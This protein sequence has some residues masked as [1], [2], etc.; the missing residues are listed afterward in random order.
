MDIVAVDRMGRPCGV[1]N[2][3]TAHQLPGTPH[4]AFSVVVAG[5]DGSVLLQRRSAEKY[6]FSGLWSNSCCSHPFPGE[7]VEAAARRRV[8][9]ELGVDLQRVAVLEGFW[10]RAEDPRSGLVE[11]EWD[12]VVTGVVAEQIRPDPDEVAATRWM[13]LHAA[14]QLCRDEPQTVTPW[15]DWV[16]AIAAAT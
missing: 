4:L 7:A 15:L 10:Y 5:G 8:K 11:H 6:H 3:L 1:V 14:R 16:L 13:Q 2:K 9:E 12:V